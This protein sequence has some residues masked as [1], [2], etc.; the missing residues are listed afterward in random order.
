MF[1]PHQGYFGK[2]AP[3]ATHRDL[4]AY[5]PTVNLLDEEGEPVGGIRH[6]FI[7]LHRD[8]DGNRAIHKGIPY[9]DT[10]HLERGREVLASKI[11]RVLGAPVGETVPTSSGVLAPYHPYRT[12][13]R[14]SQLYVAHHNPP[15]P[16]MTV[17]DWLE[18]EDNTRNDWEQYKHGLWGATK[19]GVL[20]HLI[21]NADRGS[22]NF[23]TD[24]DP[25]SEEWPCIWGIDHTHWS[26]T[27]FPGPFGRRATGLPK[28]WVNALG[29]QIGRLR[30]QFEAHLGTQ[31]GENHFTTV[32]DNL[33]DMKRYA[34]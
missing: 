15:D 27:S 33:E 9:G 2:I 10:F 34:V 13:R 26:Q 1:V 18:Q 23:L 6:N 17:N 11:G 30:P 32:M 21:G 3:N 29:Q 19:L 4:R 14:A 7:D 8:P 12:G 28:H 5:F 20:D 25:E 31:S 24:Y 22:E 16:K